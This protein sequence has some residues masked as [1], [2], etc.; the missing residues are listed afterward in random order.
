MDDKQIVEQDIEN[1]KAA[2]APVEDL[3]SEEASSGS[4]FGPV[5]RCVT[6]KDGPHAY[7][8]PAAMRNDDFVE[9]MKEVAPQLIA[10][11]P[12][13][14][15]SSS[16]S[17]S[18][19]GHEEGTSVSD[20]CPEPPTSRAPV[21]SETVPDEVLSVEVLQQ[22]HLDVDVLLA[23][24]ICTRRCRRSFH[25]VTIPKQRLMRVS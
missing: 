7:W 11:L 2:S 16:S 9:M 24:Y 14:E 1:P 5:R 19:R 18:K 8:R 25:I 22:P 6:H 3:P 4:S 10:N 13:L 20:A 17:A 21:N 12:A 23:D 15:S